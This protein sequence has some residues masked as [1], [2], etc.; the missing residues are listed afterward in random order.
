[1]MIKDSNYITILAPMVTKLKL[2]GNELLIFAIIHGFSQLE[3][4]KFNGTLGYLVK[5]TTLD[6]STL[7]AILKSL[8]AKGFIKKYEHFENRVKYCEYSSNYNSIIE[9]GIYTE[10]GTNATRVENPNTPFGKS[11][12]PPLENANTPHLENANTPFELS[13]PILIDNNTILIDSNKAG[14]NPPL[15]FPD[16]KIEE[17][18]KAKKTLFR[19]SKYAE[20][21]NFNKEFSGAEFETIDMLYYYHT[22]SDWS[23]TKNMKRTARGWL[24]TV[25]QFIRGD[26]EKK[27]LHVKHEFKPDNKK[28][29]VDGALEY[30]K[31]Y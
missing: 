4:M 31:D 14:Q 3:G 30:L 10:I 25:R 2:K 5:W 22:V 23:D 19:N 28:V 20:M 6:K 1:M 9:N 27:K 12:L 15:L 16:Q 26:V 7:I 24:A 8:E 21:E 11:E 17:E 29:T 18:D 13:K